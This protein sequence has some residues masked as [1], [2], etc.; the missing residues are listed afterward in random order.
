MSPEKS[1]SGLCFCGRSLKPKMLTFSSASARIIMWLSCV[2]V[3]VTKQNR[4]F[5]AGLSCD[6]PSGI[7]YP[8]VEVLWW[9]FKLQPSPSRIRLV[10]QIK[11]HVLLW[12]T[13][14]SWLQ[15]IADLQF[16]I[17]ILFC[18]KGLIYEGLCTRV[19]I[20]LNLLCRGSMTSLQSH[21]SGFSSLSGKSAGSASKNSAL[22]GA[23]SSCPS[24]WITQK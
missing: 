20:F 9:K 23:I 4:Y 14:V 24:R 13:Q 2:S 15:V 8:A 7:L 5:L 17:C 11:S 21:Q 10:G 18:L 19:L 12:S 3:P 16:T 6:E 1:L 22:S